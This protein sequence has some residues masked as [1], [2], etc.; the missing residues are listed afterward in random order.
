MDPL[1]YSVFEW[2]RHAEAVAAKTSE[3][4]TCSKLSD[5]IVEFFQGCRAYKTWA[6]VFASRDLTA[7]DNCEHYSW[8]STLDARPLH[9]ASSYGLVGVVERLFEGGSHSAPQK[10]ENAI[11]PDDRDGEG[12]TPLFWAVWGRHESTSRLLIDKGAKVSAVDKRGFTP[13]HLAAERGH[14]PLVQILVGKGAC[15]SATN[16]RG[17]TPLHAAA[18][19]GCDAVTRLLVEHNADPLAKNEA[20]CTPVEVAILYGHNKAAKVLIDKA[21]GIPDTDSY[22]ISALCTAVQMLGPR[23]GEDDDSLAAAVGY[24]TVQMLINLGTY[25]DLNGR[26]LLHMVVMGRG[27]DSAYYLVLL[28]RAVGTPR[29]S[30]RTRYTKLET[31][32]LLINAG[33]DVFASDASGLTPLHIAAYFG[34]VELARLL[35]DNGADISAVDKE[36]ITPLYYA[37]A[38]GQSSMAQ[39][40]IENGADVL[41][42]DAPIQPLHFAAS[43]RQIETAQLPTDNGADASAAG[44]GFLAPLCIPVPCERIEDAKP[45]T[46]NGADISP[47]A[48]SSCISHTSVERLRGSVNGSE[49]R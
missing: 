32:R 30:L 33:A 37:A 18:A 8:E 10:E 43:Y 7:F 40:L 12:R 17:E 5:M 23:V 22:R 9:I 35:I 20:K 13:L 19:S 4:G 1:Y 31:A 29:Y 44:T 48:D 27:E 2:L 45:P 47:A 14:E 21:T 38:T 26:T 39:L 42:T 25:L 41:T 15:V 34:N 49:G 46:D 6:Q 36:M 3:T 24:D 28:N 11:D 16:E